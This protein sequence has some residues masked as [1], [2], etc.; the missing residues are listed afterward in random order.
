MPRSDRRY[1]IV[2]RILAEGTWKASAA[3]HI[4]GSGNF[5]SNVD[6]ALARD[7]DYN[8]Y[9]PGAS[10]AG[11]TRSLLARITAR[12][13][14]TFQGGQEENVLA[15]MYG[16]RLTKDKSQTAYASLL[17]FDE[18][19]C[20]G[21]PVPF[22]RDSVRIDSETGNAMRR[23][24]FNHEVLPA[25]VEFRLRVQLI[26]WEQLAESLDRNT[27][28][29]WF[30]WILES[31]QEDGVRLGARTRRG[32]GRGT[33]AEW[34]IREFDMTRRADA[35]D[36]LAS[37][38]SAGGRKIGPDDLGKEPLGKANNR[39]TIDASFRVRTSLLIR[40]P[41]D[42]LNGPDTMQFTENGRR[43]APGTS[44]AG[45]LRHRV[46]RIMN[47]L[48]VNGEE[49]CNELFGNQREKH[50]ATDEPAPKE[51]GGARGEEEKAGRVFVTEAFLG[52]GHT[53]VQSRVA[54]DRFTG[55]SVE[56]RL[57]DEGPFWGDPTEASHLAVQIVVEAPQGHER[58]ALLGAFK[59]L[60]TG[61]LTL[62]GESGIG[63]GVL[64]GVEARFAETGKPGLPVM[65]WRRDPKRKDRVV[66]DGVAEWKAHLE[67]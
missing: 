42:D 60:W 1:P 14:E 10:L 16:K 53:S 17:L 40:G 65:T 13:F 26:L 28:R 18:A 30:R 6:M 46:E 57:F 12:D 8:F 51:K 61:D 59:D 4:G 22:V 52:K 66:A 31:F 23:G 9:I 29:Q 39:L 5:D 45:I 24:K 67:A 11:A 44:F 41:S 3:I 58:R 32:F 43:V 35:L 36:W 38:G 37:K 25:G 27:V 49:V 21:T 15:M 34:T 33:V 19:P 7:W 20:V 56:A 54:I 55:G 64:E 47:T 48:G 2:T 50:L 63:R 62:G